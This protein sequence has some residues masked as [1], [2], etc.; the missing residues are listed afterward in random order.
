MAP[1]SLFDLKPTKFVV[2]MFKSMALPGFKFTIWLG[3]ILGV[4][5]TRNPRNITVFTSWRSLH[6]ILLLLYNAFFAI[7][8]LDYAFNVLPANLVKKD[9]TSFLTTILTQ[10]FGQLYAILLTTMRAYLIVNAKSFSSFFKD[11]EDLSNASTRRGH[12]NCKRTGILVILAVTVVFFQ[13][14]FLAWFLSKFNGTQSWLVTLLGNRFYA[15]LA[16]FLLASPLFMLHGVVF[17]M[18]TSVMDRILD[19]LEEFCDHVHSLVQQSSGKAL[20]EEM[21]PVTHDDTTICTSSLGQNKAAII[22][23]F[24]NYTHVI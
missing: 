14:V 3:W 20:M 2:D 6:A 16:F 15:I 10:S 1:P 21:G 5:L 13:S 24:K 8:L 11:I 23:I 17:A 7:F 12:R 19:I 4:V 22:D 18:T 9:N